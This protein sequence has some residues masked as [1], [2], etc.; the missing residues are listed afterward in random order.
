MPEYEDFPVVNTVL[1]LPAIGKLRGISAPIGT[2][3]GPEWSGRYL[4][5]RGYTDGVAIIAPAMA[6][7]MAAAKRRCETGEFN[8]TAEIVAFSAARRRA[9]AEERG[10]I[11]ELTRA[12]P[13]R[14]LH[15]SSRK[16]VHYV[17]GWR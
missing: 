8:S 10:R 9:I 13:G 14:G 4:V 7:D 1:P 6:D 17:K 16:R 2:I 5:V 11:R 12:I 15:R 3:V